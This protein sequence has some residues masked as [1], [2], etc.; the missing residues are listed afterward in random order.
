MRGLGLLA[1][2][3]RVFNLDIGR[4]DLDQHLGALRLRFLFCLPALLFCLCLEAMGILQGQPGLL[5]VSRQFGLCSLESRF[6]V[7][8]QLITDHL[9][10]GF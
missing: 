6:R 5:G 10:L 4:L 8:R 2:A 3:L 9:V 1:Q 7:A